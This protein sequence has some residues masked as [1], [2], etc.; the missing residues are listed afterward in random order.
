M[1]FKSIEEL[2]VHFYPSE[3]EIEK[4][5]LRK[6]IRRCGRHTTDFSNLLFRNG[7]NSIKDL[8]D[9][10]VSKIEKFHH[11]G[12]KKMQAIIEAKRIINDMLSN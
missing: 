2:T 4:E 3:Q 8:H 5:A 12:P 6:F 11:I 10:D 7:I 1:I 9:V